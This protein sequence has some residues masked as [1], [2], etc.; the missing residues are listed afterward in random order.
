[1]RRSRCPCLLWPRRNEDGSGVSA[2]QQIEFDVIPQLEV[3]KEA[4]TEEAIAGDTVGYTVTIVNHSYSQQM[5]IDTVVDT[6]LDDQN[7]IS[8]GS[9]TGWDTTEN[10][11]IV[12]VLSPTSA[13][14]PRTTATATYQ[15]TIAAGDTSSS[16]V[17]TFLASGKRSADQAVLTAEATV[18]VSL[19][20]A[21]QVFFNVTNIDDFPQDIPG[22]TLRWEIELFNQSSQPVTIQSVTDTLRWPGQPTIPISGLGVGGSLDGF[23]I[24]YVQDP[25]LTVPSFEMLI[26]PKYY[27]SKPGFEDDYMPETVTVNMTQNG[28]PRACVFSPKPKHYL[29]SP[30]VGFKQPDKLLAFPGDTVTYSLMLATVADPTDAPWDRYLITSVTDTVTKQPIL[31]P[32]DRSGGVFVDS[33]SGQ[34]EAQ[35]DLATGSNPTAP[36]TFPPALPAPKLIPYTVQ[37]TD[38]NPLV[39]TVTVEFQ[40]MDGN[41]FFT[42]IVAPEV[43]T[44]NPLELIKILKISRRL[45][46]EGR[47]LPISSGYTTA[48]PTHS[49]TSRR[50]T[51]GDRMCSSLTM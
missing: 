3:I 49:N 21:V 33:S 34:L 6:L 36:P 32:F 43:E 8:V 11:G 28:I 25:A 42:T 19:E 20:C 29:Y 48:A 45:R 9:F 31:L 12:G 39:N 14:V 44:T 1:M 50:G 24:A 13:A 16:L 47:M 5:R 15:Y 37:P 18:V 27:G 23:G 26:E 41:K 35:I 4:N 22:E 30:I 2:T 51:S 17:N 10:G 7:T 40:D 38:P 46:R